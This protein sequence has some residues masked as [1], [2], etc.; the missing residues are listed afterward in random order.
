MPWH[1]VA[2]YVTIGALM[3]SEWH[4]NGFGETSS[5][6]LERSMEQEVEG[7]LELDDL[8]G[9]ADGS[10]QITVD[11]LHAERGGPHTPERAPR[12]QALDAANPQS[13]GRRAAR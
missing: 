7:L 6:E 3:S 11:L 4:E 10:E 1:V 8:D 9:P 2:K 13:S 5:E 12:Q